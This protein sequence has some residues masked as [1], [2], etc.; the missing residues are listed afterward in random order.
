MANFLFHFDRFSFGFHF[1][2]ISV[3]Y[4]KEKKRIQ[5]VTMLW[6]TCLLFNLFCAYTTFCNDCQRLDG[7]GILEKNHFF[8][9]SSWAKI[10]TG[11]KT[12]R[13]TNNKRTSPTTFINVIE[14]FSI[15]IW[16]RKQNGETNLNDFDSKLEIYLANVAYSRSVFIFDV[17]ANSSNRR[18]KKI[19][20]WMPM[21]RQNVQNIVDASIHFSIRCQ[22]IRNEIDWI[23]SRN[24]ER[25]QLSQI[26]IEHR[27]LHPNPL[28]S[29]NEQKWH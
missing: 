12:K 6:Q 13:A 27:G 9:F 26:Q 7:R 1:L 10:R 25:K 29:V 4:L 23:Y 8:F 17:F 16:K 15:F 21:V 28:T 18:R 2:T 11:K 3:S 5:I 14:Y 22:T 24:V 19:A 20:R